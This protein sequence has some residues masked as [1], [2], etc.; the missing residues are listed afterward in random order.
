[1]GINLIDFD[2]NIGRQKPENIRHKDAPCPFCDRE[3]LTNI[4][5]V[6]DDM[7]LLR[8]KYNVVR[9]SEQFV[10]IEG[11]DCES[12]MPA[13]SRERMHRLIR[14]GVRHWQT[15][16]H[17]G[18]YESVLFFK[19][20]GPYSGGTIRHPHMQI[21][22]FPHLEENQLYLPQEF[23]GAT[24]FECEGTRLTVSDCP[25]IGF[26]EFNVIPASLAPEAIDT[27]ADY[28]Q[29]SV[30]YIMH[31]FGAN[32]NS[33]NIFFYRDSEDA[34]RFYVKVLP[35]FATPPLFIGY[36]IRLRPTNL[37]AA[38]QEMRELYPKGTVR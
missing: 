8:N 26:W 2:T 13:Y 38:V 19:N 32:V 6:E 17:S 18:K 35:R 36:G 33:Y 27:T 31:H 11:K 34:E 1:M 14:F 23:K 22:A 25:R 21:V 4:L 9:G 30:D 28:I 29:V 24:V 7:I 20:Y 10:L 12:D 16:I 5:D 15:M 37:N 3:H